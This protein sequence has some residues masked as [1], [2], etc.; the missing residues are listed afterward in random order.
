MGMYR[1]LIFVG[2]QR[3]KV[4]GD[5]FISSLAKGKS[6][7]MIVLKLASVRLDSMIL[8]QRIYAFTTA[9]M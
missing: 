6:V 3:Y 4:S 5:L 1:A 9:L 8:E 2:L 7:I